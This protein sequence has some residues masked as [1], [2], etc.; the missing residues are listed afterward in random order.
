[1]IVGCRGNGGGVES[2][3]AGSEMETIGE[4]VSGESEMTVSYTHLDV[5][6]RQL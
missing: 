2:E 4:I 6:K 5:Y 1:M 3:M